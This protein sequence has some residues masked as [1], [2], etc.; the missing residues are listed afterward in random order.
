MNILH[1]SDL[2]FGSIADADKWY[3]QLI[4]DLNYELDCFSLDLLIL[5]GDIANRATRDEYYAAEV[6]LEKLFTK[7]NLTSEQ[8]VIV[9]GN[10]DV[11][12]V[13]ARRAYTPMR[14]SDYTGEID[15]GLLIDNEQYIEVKDPNLYL[16]RF[17]EF[18]KFYESIKGTEYPSEYENQFTINYL[19]DRKLI[20][21]GLNSAWD[22]DHFYSSRA[23]I[24]PVAL[25][26]ALD[27]L[28]DKDEVFKQCLKIAVW[29]HPIHSSENDRI[30]DVDFLQRLSVAGFR[31]ALHGHIHKAQ[32]NIFHYDVDSDGRQINIIAAG[33]FGAATHEWVP[34]YPLQYNFLELEGNNLKVETRSRKEINGAWQPEAIWLQGPKKAPKSYYEI[35]IPHTGD[36]SLSQDIARLNTVPFSLS[37]RIEQL[38]QAESSRENQFYLPPTIPTSIIDRTNEKQDILNS[39][40]GE[41]SLIVIT[42]PA[43]VGKTALAIDAVHTATKENLFERI[44]Y[45]TAKTQ[46]YVIE[47]GHTRLLQINPFVT[48]FD[49]ILNEIGWQTGNPISDLA[50]QP[51][52]EKILAILTEYTCLITIDNY[53][54]IQDKQ[55]A[56][57]FFRYRI[58]HGSKFLITSREQL[59]SGNLI[60]LKGMDSDNGVEFLQT[61]IRHYKL[62]PE[63]A[64]N[65]EILNQIVRWSGGVPLVM[66]LVVGQFGLNPDWESLDELLSKDLQDEE[67]IWYCFEGIYKH[68]TLG[69]KYVMQALAMLP[70]QLSRKKLCDITGL[71]SGFIVEATESLSSKSLLELSQK[72]GQLWYAILPVTRAYVK[73]QA[74]E[75]R[76]MLWEKA[77]DHYCDMSTTDRDVYKNL[78]QNFENILFILEWCI[79]VNRKKEIV[80]LF[81]Y[82]SQYLEIRGMINK[83]EEY[84]KI[85][86]DA[87]YAISWE[88]EGDWIRAYDLA[89]IHQVRGGAEREKAKQIYLSLIQKL[90]GSSSDESMR[91]LALCYRNLALMIARENKERRLKANDDEAISNSNI[92]D[93]LEFAKK[94]LQIWKEVGDE[95]M[96][97]ITYGV[98]GGLAQEPKKKLVEYNRALMLARKNGD[99]S[100]IAQWLSNIGRAYIKAGELENAIKYL[101]QAMEQAVEAKWL[102]GLAYALHYKALISENNGDLKQSRDH[103]VQAA[104]IESEVGSQR[105]YRQLLSDIES[106]D[107]RLNGEPGW[108]L[109]VS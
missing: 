64:E 26:R 39:L 21:L 51:K 43:G 58:P 104:N 92:D 61:Y 76:A 82:I 73:R 100:A 53:D 50:R 67:M 11:N 96:L 8:V 36:I 69:E 74:F 109:S 4:H 52:L 90:D 72:D 54:T 2:H 24:H 83:R 88:N 17:R 3:S 65:T 48:Q 77:V 38:V 25:S 108:P 87:A 89:W 15:E 35:A 59:S 7:Y 1:L 75:E 23:S 60:K 57:S 13:A 70:G 56:E 19:A 63:L 44:V 62:W 55:I 94:S 16:E 105:H 10:H 34:G 27:S 86:I 78:E 101:D 107:L 30:K 106:I 85:A 68:L 98:I 79:Q 41:A 102:S 12:W 91:V 22:L 31:L 9:P 95:H 37:R 93:A 71:V 103:L 40:K 80:Q 14:R 81:R 29:H 47:P 5:S 45:I 42:G 18:S 6:F 32:R 28:L 99:T 49:D 20:V 46:E 84:A 33:T 66:K 97:A